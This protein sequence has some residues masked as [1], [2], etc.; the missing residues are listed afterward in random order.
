MLDLHWPGFGI[1]GIVELWSM[2]S[3]TK[4]SLDIPVRGLEGDMSEIKFHGD[5]NRT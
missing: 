2:E 1:R 3:F 5:R 4:S